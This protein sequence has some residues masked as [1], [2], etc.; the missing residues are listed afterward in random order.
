MARKPDWPTLRVHLEA[1]GIDVNTE[2]LFLPAKDPEHEEAWP[3]WEA[4]EPLLLPAGKDARWETVA[5]HLVQIETALSKRVDLRAESR[6][7]RYPNT[8]PV[9][10]TATRGL[11]AGV[12]ETDDV[13]EALR[14]LDLATRAA[15]HAGAG[16]V[17]ISVL[18]SALAHRH[19]LEA[20]GNLIERRPSGE[21]NARLR[22]ILA[23]LVLPPWRGIVASELRFSLGYVDLAA[24][25]GD[26]A[27]RSDENGRRYH[28]ALQKPGA[29]ERAKAIVGRAYGK[30]L[31]ACAGPVPDE[32]DDLA[33]LDRIAPRLEPFWL[34]WYSPDALTRAMAVSSGAWSALPRVYRSLVGYHRMVRF[35]SLAA[36]LPVGTTFSGVEDL[37]ERLGTEGWDPFLRN[38][39]RVRDE[40]THWTF[41]ANAF[42]EVATVR[43]PVP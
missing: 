21:A 36:D 32:I 35:A 13:E 37:R 40:G 43:L 22:R 12:A 33:M 14:R 6:T 2:G 10:I 24:D 19:V 28:Q 18:V 11:S 3:A 16:P 34:L 7:I 41:F 23:P 20:A 27:L 29:P 30:V 38:P 4:L 26:P 42:K 5:P 8:L 9:T 15:L 17:L 25:G 39:L 1:Q 31:T